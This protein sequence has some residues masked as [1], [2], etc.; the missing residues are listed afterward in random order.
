MHLFSTRE[1]DIFCFE[2]IQ[3]IFPLQI[4]FDV[5]QLLT[6]LSSQFRVNVN[7]RAFSSANEIDR[8]QAS[9]NSINLNKEDVFGRSLINGQTKDHVIF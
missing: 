7:F 6:L 4:R 2:S 3:F 8:V 5:S 9:A 1:Y